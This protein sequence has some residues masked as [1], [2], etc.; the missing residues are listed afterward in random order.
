M[1]V[2]PFAVRDVIILIA[3]QEAEAQTHLVVR[4]VTPGRGLE[5]GL[6]PVFG[7]M[8]CPPIRRHKASFPWLLQVPVTLGL[9][10]FHLKVSEEGH[11]YVDHTPW[12]SQF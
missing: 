5:G 4:P 1:P 6:W 10:E 11:S 7:V 8:L 9:S 2:E 12:L 3:N